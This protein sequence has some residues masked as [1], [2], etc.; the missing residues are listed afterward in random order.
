MKIVRPANIKP[1][2]KPKP[3]ETGASSI[4]VTIEASMPSEIDA[5]SP[6][7]D[8]LMRLIEGSCCITGSEFAVELALREAL[9][10]AV[11]HGNAMDPLK[12]VKVRC[13]CESGQ[14]LWLSVADQGKGFDPGAIADPLKRSSLNAEHGRGIYLMN[15]AMDRVVFESGGTE[16]RMW[17]GAARAGRLEHPNQA[18]T[19]RSYPNREP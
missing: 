8:Q 4:C 9:N 10:N 5:I 17:K 14:G 13:R 16:V 15:W 12:L 7:M 18:F 6:L 1:V 11:V 2:R 19:G 3:R